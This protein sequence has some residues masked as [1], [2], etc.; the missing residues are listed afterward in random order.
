ML[1]KADPGEEIE[2]GWTGV[3]SAYRGRGI[4]Q[5]M[6]I[7]AIEYAKANNHPIIWT[8]INSLNESSMAINKAFGFQRELA[9]VYYTKVLRS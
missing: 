6:K 2:T 1:E 5:A 4:G 7:R 8:T 3:D 9:W